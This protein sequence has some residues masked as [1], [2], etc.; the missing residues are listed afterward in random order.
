LGDACDAQDG[1]RCVRPP[2]P[3]A[4]GG[5]EH[6]DQTVGSHKWFLSASI[7]A[8]A[9]GKCIDWIYR[10]SR[11]QSHR[12]GWRLLSLRLE[13]KRKEEVLEESALFISLCP[14]LGEKKNKKTINDIFFLPPAFHVLSLSAHTTKLDQITVGIPGPTRR[15][16]G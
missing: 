12:G 5:G 9:L 14:V 10:P 16:G 13:K 6:S 8:R 2:R 3:A 15:G 11:S 1:P 7:T 4:Y